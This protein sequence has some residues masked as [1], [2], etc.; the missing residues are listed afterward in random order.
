MKIQALNVHHLSCTLEHTAWNSNTA[1]ATRPALVVEVVTADGISGWGS[2]SGGARG[3][4]ERLAAAAELVETGGGEVAEM[5][6]VVELEALGG[7]SRLTG[8]PFHT[9]LAV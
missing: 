4:E 2:A 3:G 8:R 6:V 5:G 7:R 1:H 9:L